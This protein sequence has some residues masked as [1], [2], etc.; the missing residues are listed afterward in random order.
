VSGDIGDYVKAM[1]WDAERPYAEFPVEV[2]A[3][4]STYYSDCYYQDAGQ[5]VA[6]VGGFWFLGGSVGPS[7]WNMSSHSS[8]PPV[9]A[10]GRLLKKPL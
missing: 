3:S 1:G 5:R 2:G 9:N 7:C 6:R 8:T 10:G 4:T